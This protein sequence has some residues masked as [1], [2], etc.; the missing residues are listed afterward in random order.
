MKY[1]YII[2]A[3]IFLILLI[4][5]ANIVGFYI[6]IFLLFLALISRAVSP[7]KRSPKEDIN[8]ITSSDH[9]IP[10]QSVLSK[11]E[12]ADPEAVDEDIEREEI[13]IITPKNQAGTKQKNM[14]TLTNSQLLNDYKKAT[15]KDVDVRNFRLYYK[16]K[17]TN[18]IWYDG[19]IIY[20][21]KDYFLMKN[22]VNINHATGRKC[23]LYKP[24]VNL[25]DEMKEKNIKFTLAVDIEELMNRLNASGLNKAMLLSD[26]LGVETAS[27]VDYSEYNQ[28]IYDEDGSWNI[29]S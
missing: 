16:D 3:G 26:E 11:H 5:V 7:N 24:E 18:L 20:V 19:H 2:I 8:I 13:D 22:L 17:P 23:V 4:T 1:L 25:I 14:L 9:H 27:D 15:D 29:K 12:S 6:A 10:I 21:P 28:P